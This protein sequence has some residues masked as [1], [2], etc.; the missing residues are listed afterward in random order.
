MFIH[1]EVGKFLA[2]F[3]VQRLTEITF[4]DKNRLF[5]PL[6]VK[7]SKIILKIHGRNGRPIAL[8]NVT[9][10]SHRCLVYRYTSGIYIFNT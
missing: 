5:I 6:T 1:T 3:V 10:N 9:T 7:K 8:V 2:F 4:Q